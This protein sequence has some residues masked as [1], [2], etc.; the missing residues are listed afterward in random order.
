[1]TLTRLQKPL[2]RVVGSLVVTIDAHG[3]EIRGLRKRKLR[4]RLTWA[5]VAALESEPSVLRVAEQTAGARELQR[6]AATLERGQ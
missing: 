4:K 5:Q 1:M 6:L 2:T 3:V